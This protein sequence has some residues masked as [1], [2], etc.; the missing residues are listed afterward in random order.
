MSVRGRLLLFA[1]VAW[2]QESGTAIR[3]DPRETD[4]LDLDWRILPIAALHGLLFY[5]IKRAFLLRERHQGTI[6]W[7]SI[8][9]WWPPISLAWAWINLA[10]GSRTNPGTFIDAWTIAFSVVSLSA[11]AGSAVYWLCLH[12]TVRWIERRVSMSKPVSLGIKTVSA[13]DGHR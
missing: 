9:C 13:T 6:P 2:A 10:L 5:A 12:G 7:Q 4:Q 1:N 3:F 11:L 8:R